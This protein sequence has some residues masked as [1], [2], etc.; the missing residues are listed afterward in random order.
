MIGT[1]FCIV[2]NKS[3]IEEDFVVRALEV[4]ILPCDLLR[5]W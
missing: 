5:N 4:A 3:I 1:Y 2:I